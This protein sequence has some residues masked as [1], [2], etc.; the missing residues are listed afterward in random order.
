VSVGIQRILR[1]L[2]QN[3]ANICHFLL[4]TVRSFKRI[5]VHSNTLRMN[6]A[7][8]EALGMQYIKVKKSEAIPVGSLGGL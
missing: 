5:T 4:L 7:N 2:Y 8:D 1:F 3:S 6:A